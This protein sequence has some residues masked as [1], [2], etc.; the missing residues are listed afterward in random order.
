MNTIIRYPWLLWP[1]GI[2]AGVLTGSMW[3][4]V[5]FCVLAVA[6]VA[7]HPTV[8]KKAKKEKPVKSIYQD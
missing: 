3:V 5:L 6:V 4:I 7:K 8:E 1:I 2:L